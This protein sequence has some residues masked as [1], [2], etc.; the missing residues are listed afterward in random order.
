MNIYNP[1]G[2]NLQLQN[3]LT[4]SVYKNTIIAGDFNSHSPAWGYKDLDDNGKKVEELVNSTNLFL[5]QNNQT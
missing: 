2:N 3:T 1:P 5:V 4:E